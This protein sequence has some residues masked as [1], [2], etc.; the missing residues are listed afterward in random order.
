METFEVTTELHIAL[1]VKV[2]VEADDKE[3][4]VEAAGSLMPNNFDRD[5][6]IGW[7][8]KVALK[9][10]KDVNIRVVRAYH[11]TG[12]SGGEKVRKITKDTP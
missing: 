10:P 12:A 3:A 7:K 5:S 11:L 4:A 8:A 6:Q 2:T 1:T 9:A